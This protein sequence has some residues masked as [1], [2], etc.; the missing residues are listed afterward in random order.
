MSESH[1]LRDIIVRLSHSSR[2]LFRMHVGTYRAL[3]SDE[4]IHIGT[5]GMAD[6]VGLQ[7]V[8]VT[9]E[10]VGQRLAVFVAI[11]VKAKAGRP[12]QNQLDFIHIVQQLG[13]R[14]GIARTVEEA[15][16]IL[17]LRCDNF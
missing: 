14:A 12:R 1:V 10:M 13:G 2:R 5:P 17:L 7:S 11:E 4:V 9:P 6:L 16:K 3:H 8:V 15:E